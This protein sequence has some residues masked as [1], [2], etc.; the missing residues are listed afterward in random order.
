MIFTPYLK[1]S[2]IIFS[3]ILMR[4]FQDFFCTFPFI[5]VYALQAMLVFNEITT[6]SKED[7]FVPFA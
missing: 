1:C 5:V 4:E 2:G 3:K 6:S 7:L